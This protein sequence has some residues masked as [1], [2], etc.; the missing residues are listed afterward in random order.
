[1]TIP[2]LYAALEFLNVWIVTNKA[3]ETVFAWYVNL[4]ISLLMHL[5]AFHVAQWLPTV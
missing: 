5:H 2:V 4:L 3:L 1:M